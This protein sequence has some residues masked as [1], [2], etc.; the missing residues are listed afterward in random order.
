VA[1][2]V[3]LDPTTHADE[4]AHPPA[5][6]GNGWIRT[7]RGRV[8]RRRIPYLARLRELAGNGTAFDFVLFLGDVVFKAQ[9][10][11]ALINTNNGDYA[12]ARALDFIKPPR[13]YDTFALRA[14]EGH[15]HS[16]VHVAVL[17]RGQVPGR[18]EA[19]PANA[20]FE[21]LGRHG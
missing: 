21:L 5:V 12:A 18:H 2:E 11:I 19:E 7:P 13:Y 8:E 14:S 16:H 9:D 15:E 17:P 3:V 20:G 10:V 1:R 6:S 4:I